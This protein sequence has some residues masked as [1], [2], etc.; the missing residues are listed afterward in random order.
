MRHKVY[1]FELS[2]L[3]GDCL[4]CTRLPTC[5]DTTLTQVKESFTCPLF[6]GVEEPVYQARLV[7]ISNYGE[8]TAINAMMQHPPKEEGE[9]Q[10]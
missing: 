1:G 8:D 2:R 3:S 10:Q 6:Q 7:M 9:E 4:S 5:L